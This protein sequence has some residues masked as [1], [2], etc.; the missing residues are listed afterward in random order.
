MST[1]DISAAPATVGR[2]PGLNFW[3]VAFAFLIVMA[4][5]TRAH[6]DEGEG[7]FARE[8]VERMLLGRLGEPEDVANFA[9]FHASDESS[10]IN[11][12][13]LVIDGGMKVW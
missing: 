13:R 8:M 7:G 11:W 3:A 5:A 4:F 1:N 6:L 10:Y 9:L 2:R 12:R